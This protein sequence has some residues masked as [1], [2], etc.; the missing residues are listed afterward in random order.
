MES[1]GKNLRVSR[2]ELAVLPL[3]D[4][5]L[6]ATQAA[7]LDP[8]D[9]RKSGLSLNHII[10]CPLD[11]A[12]C[13]RHLFGNF[14]MKTPRRI[15]SDADAVQH[16]VGHKYFVPHRTP[17]QIFNR[18]T[19]PFL[20]AVKP[21]TFRVLE[22]L[23]ARGLSNFVLLI[24]RY[25][26]TSEDAE[27]LNRFAP[28]KITLLVTYSGI[29]DSCLEPASSNMAATS[30]ERAYRAARSY[31]VVLY[32]RPLVPDL[33]DSDEHIKRAASLSHTAHAT[34]FT[35]L[36]FRN[37]IRAYYESAGLSAP[38]DETARRKVLPQA[39]EARVLTGFHRNKGRA[40]FRK[41][42]CAVSFAHALP[43]YN[44]HI[45]IREICDICPSVQ[46]QRC[47]GAWKRP[48]EAEVESITRSIDLSA[49][50]NINERAVV[51]D[52]LDEQPRYYVQHALGYQVHDRR[53]PHFL[54]RHGRADVGWSE[55]E[56]DREN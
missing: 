38:F 9:Y 54:G 50:F 49:R 11:C 29:E 51:F 53:R 24:T 32:W 46:M 42:S 16:L 10:G 34:A 40:I 36:F 27:R 39:L 45:G 48:S 15:M 7:L 14:E 31:R 30:L 41:T 47:S 37:E 6:E 1:K 44:G 17:L 22:L 25:K 13:V 43:D 2:R 20:P 28:L 26:V 4:E 12:Y 8:V 21:S 3:A 55:T 56:N 35:G 19:D 23:A 5:E 52:E 18:A 33:N